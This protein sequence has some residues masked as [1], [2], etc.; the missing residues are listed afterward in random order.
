MKKFTLFLER[1]SGCLLFK[2]LSIQ[3][4]SIYK[5]GVFKN[6]RKDADKLFEKQNSSEADE[7]ANFDALLHHFTCIILKSQRKLQS[8]KVFWVRD[9]KKSAVSS[10][11]SN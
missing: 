1:N 8:L 11:V 6:G 10:T 7:L 5:Q 9:F 4:Q 2:I 3:I